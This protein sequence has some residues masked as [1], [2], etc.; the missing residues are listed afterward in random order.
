MG[1][2]TAIALQVGAG[3]FKGI[4]AKKAGDK[5]KKLFEA[6]AAVV[7]KEAKKEA[8]RLRRIFKVQNADRKLGFLK[9]GVALFGSPENIISTGISLQSE[10]VQSVLERGKAQSQFLKLQGSNAAKEGRAQLIGN[11]FQGVTS[12]ATTFAVGKQ[13]GAF[14]KDISTEKFGTITSKDARLA[15]RHG[16]LL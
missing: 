4:Q 13:F 5:Q 6:E 16:I 8:G 12:G 3:V 10:E 9:H 1:L 15:G 14:D 7:E 2:G 11:I